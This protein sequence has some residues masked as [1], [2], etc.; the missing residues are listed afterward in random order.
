M[1]A[2]FVLD[3]FSRV[4]VGWQVATTMHTDLALDALNRG[5][6]RVIVPA[7]TWQG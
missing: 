5:G 3:V 2:A 1:Y 7:R 6:G 4:V